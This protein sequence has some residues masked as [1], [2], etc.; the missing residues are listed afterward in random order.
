MLELYSGGQ[1]SDAIMFWDNYDLMRDSEGNLIRLPD[2]RWQ[3]EAGF[4]GGTF[5]GF[6]ASEFF[7]SR[8]LV[9]HEPLHVYYHQ[10]PEVFNYDY[11]REHA[12]IYR[13]GPICGGA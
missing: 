13:M 11:N 7:R 9:G 8:A 2:G 6:Q 10:H 3:F 1:K 5:L 4:N 12:H